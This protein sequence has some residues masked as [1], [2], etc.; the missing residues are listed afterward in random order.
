MNKDEEEAHRLRDPMLSPE[1]AMMNPRE[2]M[3]AL[4]MHSA[5]RP[6][7]PSPNRGT[8]PDSQGPEREWVVCTTHL[9]E[10]WILLECRKTMAYGAVKQPTCEEWLKCSDM[11]YGGHHSYPWPEYWRVTFLPKGWE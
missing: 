1:W 10:G 11:M 6:G 4:R 3:Q 5:T 2:R 9:T 8:F 7:A